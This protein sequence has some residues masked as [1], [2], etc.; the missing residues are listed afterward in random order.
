[1]M[2]RGLRILFACAVA[3]FVIGTGGFAALMLIPSPPQATNSRPRR[4]A[5]LSH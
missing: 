3:L 2:T 1:M 5:V 4:S